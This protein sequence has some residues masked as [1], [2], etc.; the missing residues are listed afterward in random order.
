MGSESE[1]EKPNPILQMLR[2]GNKGIERYKHLIGV[3]VFLMLLAFS[4]IYMYALSEERKMAE[5]CGFDDGKIKCVCTE[6]AWNDYQDSLYDDFAL[7]M[8]VNSKSNNLNNVNTSIL[9]DGS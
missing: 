7:D 3:G 1:S 5:N 4:G 9:E 8:P 6:D 2:E